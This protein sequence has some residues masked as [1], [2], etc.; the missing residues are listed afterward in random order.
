MSLYG[1]VL[2]LLMM[3]TPAGVIAGECCETGCLGDS[4]CDVGGCG[5]GSGCGLLD[6]L[7]SGLVSD[8]KLLGL[9][10]HSDPCFN[11]FISPMS[12]PVFFEDPRTLTEVRF[13]FLDHQLPNAL[14]GD[15]VQVYAAQARLALTEN[16][17]IIATKDGYVVSQSPVLDD[18]FADVSA[19]LKYNIFKDYESQTIVS[20]G[21]T[22][23]MPVGTERAIQGNGDGEFNLFLSAGT[24]IWE[25]AHWISGAGFRLPANRALENQVFYWSNHLDQ[26]LGDSGVYL[27]TEANWFHYMSGANAF[28]LPI[29]GGDL[30]NLGAPVGGENFVS[31]AF[32][33]KLKPQDNVEIGVA[34]EVPYSSRKDLMKDRINVN[35]IWRY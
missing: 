12:N 14:G 25:G 19:G 35:F 34:Y 6:G 11:D 27:F 18:G 33:V 8:D 24:E 28:P 4:C 23:E 21:F 22:F 32:G 29:G 31:G 5:L 16:L 17:S 3:A 15:H 10:A 26:E 30:F 9:F 1:R 7:G 20:A 13:I 2:A